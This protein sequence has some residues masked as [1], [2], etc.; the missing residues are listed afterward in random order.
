VGPANNR[1]LIGTNIPVK[2][3][4]Q[5]QSYT[6][7]QVVWRNAATG[8]TLATSSY[9]SKMTPGI[10]VTPGFAGLQYFLTEDG[11]IIAPRSDPELRADA[12]FRSAGGRRR[13]GTRVH[14]RSMIGSEQ[15]Q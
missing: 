11:H 15:V 12:L 1:V 2:Y 7:E 6:T 14:Q 13:V 5:L 8:A 9:F 10:L 4:K 3:F